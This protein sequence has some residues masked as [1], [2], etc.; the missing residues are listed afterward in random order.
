[1]GDTKPEKIIA[2]VK[3]VDNE[4]GPSNGFKKTRDTV[5]AVATG[6]GLDCLWVK[7]LCGA[8]FFAPLLPG[9]CGPPS[10]LHI[11]YRVVARDKVAMAPWF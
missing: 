1:V 11:A 5:V 9:H 10:F 8:I 4:C 3:R 6:Y 7:Y 2:Y